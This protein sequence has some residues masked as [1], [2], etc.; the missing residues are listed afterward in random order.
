[1]P[2]ADDVSR[3]VRQENRA[4][5]RRPEL[6]RN[7]RGAGIGQQIPCICGGMLFIGLWD[8]EI[9]ANPPQM[10]GNDG[11]HVFGSGQDLPKVSTVTFFMTWGFMGRS[12]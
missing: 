5:I 12:E 10:R 9:T 2:E 11:Q 1:M 6:Y 8:A 3:S 4:V 7:L